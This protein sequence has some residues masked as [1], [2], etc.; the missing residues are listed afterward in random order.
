VA[1]PRLRWPVAGLEL[2]E[3]DGGAW[4]Q[5]TGPPPD[6]PPA[7]LARLE[8]GRPVPRSPFAGLLRLTELPV[9]CRVRV[10][11]DAG[12]PWVLLRA[13]GTTLQPEPREVSPP[14]TQG[15]PP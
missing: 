12:D 3:Y 1:T 15:G 11:G 7:L 10:E 8:Q 2:A 6:A 5:R 14:N 4:L 9:G 13:D